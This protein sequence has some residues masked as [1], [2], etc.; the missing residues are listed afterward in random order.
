MFQ[1]FRRDIEIKM[2]YKQ[3]KYCVFENGIVVIRDVD[4]IVVFWFDR[5]GEVEIE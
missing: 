4:V 3:S 1:C 5:L 2:L